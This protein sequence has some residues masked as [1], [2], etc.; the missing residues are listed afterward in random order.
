[1][2]GA[3][4]AEKGDS[5]G[6]LWYVALSLLASAL[7]L[8]TIGLGLLG[9]RH[10]LEQ[11]RS[12]D[13]EIGM[14]YYRRG[15]LHLEEGNYLLALAEFEAAVQLAPDYT[16]AQEQLASVQALVGDQTTSTVVPGGEAA[17]TLYG[18]ARSLYADERWE[19]VILNLEQLRHLDSAYQRQEVEEM[20][21]NAYFQQ[22]LI[23]M[24][25]GELEE[26]LVHL[27]SALEIRPDDQN[28]SD[29]R[30][31]LSLYLAGLTHWGIDWEKVVETL[32]ELYELNPTFLNVEQKLHD[33]YLSLGDR[34]YE[35]GAWCVA[36]QQYGAALQVVVTQAAIAKRD[37]ARQLCVGA[38]SAATPPAVLT[39]I[40]T[41]PITPTATVVPS[42]P[43]RGYLGEFTGYVEANAAE[44][45][46]RVHVVNAQGESVAGAEVRISAD[47]WSGDTRM[48]DADGYCEFAGFTQELEFTVSL[49]QL[50]CTPV[51][52]YTRQGQE[53]QVNF[54]ER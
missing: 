3:K 48:A 16:E 52:V 44:M 41:Q 30:L 40:P 49:M 53:A 14:E 51:Q 17:S 7:L 6:F 20:L 21:F 5:P 8:A 39:A 2:E 4:I 36:E 19:E 33:A 43:A 47:G 54:I 22:A 38:V 12:R 50:P 35:E 46:I 9:A 23:L 13:R 18:E 11:R 10:G 31:W 15:L 45:R 26:A 34:Y 37:G 42:P 27:D 32:Q 29:Q 1:M 25:A 24:E 28:V